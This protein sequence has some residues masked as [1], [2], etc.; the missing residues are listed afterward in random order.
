VSIR[1]KGKRA[2][3]TGDLIHNPVQFADPNICSNLDVD[4][5][6]ALKT[7]GALI[8]KH[9]SRDI[10]VLGTHF[11][12]PSGGYIVADDEAFRFVSGSKRSDN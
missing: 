8:R 2:V 10:L 6:L 3:I 11:P 1:S 9:V 7:R 4:K 5:S 12:M